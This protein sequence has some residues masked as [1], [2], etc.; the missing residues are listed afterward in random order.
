[1]MRR[2]VKRRKKY[3]TYREKGR[4]KKAEKNAWTRP[5]RRSRKKVQLI[6]GLFNDAF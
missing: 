2:I 1:M 4:G 3:V 5:G 6:L